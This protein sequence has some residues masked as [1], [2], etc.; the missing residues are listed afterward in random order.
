MDEKFN[1]RGYKALFSHPR[2]VEA[3]LRSFVHEDF[4]DA[5][6]FSTLRKTSDTFITE[7]FRQRES[8]IVWELNIRGQP[9]Y[10]YLLIEFQSTVERFMALRLLTY[11]LLFYG[12]LLKRGG[13]Q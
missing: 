6:D 8:D 7:E 4:L 13:V 9:A 5:L 12:D 3:L 10:V 11:V 1:D 2:M